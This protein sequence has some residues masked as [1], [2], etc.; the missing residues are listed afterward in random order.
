[1]IRMSISR[2]TSV[3]AIAATLVGIGVVNA[4]AATNEPV[5]Q[6]TAST[7]DCADGAL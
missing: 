7:K 4:Q 1:M 3:L 5:P 6:P 2:F